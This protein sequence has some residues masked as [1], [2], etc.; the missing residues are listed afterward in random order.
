MSESE[1][2]TGN[3]QWVNPQKKAETPAPY[4]YRAEKPFSL[5]DLEIDKLSER[6]A[7]IDQQKREQAELLE[8]SRQ[9]EAI[10]GP[11]PRATLEDMIKEDRA[12]FYQGEE[13]APLE[14]AS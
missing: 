6:L 4:V 3:E 13:E 2:N 5:A 9:N 14:K 1:Q 8:R 10:N 11:Q 12:E 7:K